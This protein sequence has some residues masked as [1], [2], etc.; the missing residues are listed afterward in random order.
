LQCWAKEEVQHGEALGRW[1]E[2]ADESFSLKQSFARFV[3]GYRPDVSVK[4]S[5]R[6]SLSGELIARCIVE[7]GTSSYYTTLAEAVEEPVL[8]TICLKI[9]ADELRHYKFFYD[10]LKTYLEKEKLNK[11]DRVK[12]GV[13]RM[14]E[15]E[16][17]ELAYA[18]YAANTA[19]DTIYNRA[20]YAAE[21]MQ[22]ALRYYKPHHVERMI[23]MLFKACGLRTNT[24]WQGFATKVA[25]WVRT[26][27]TER[28]L[29]QAA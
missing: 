17:D 3:A 7:T 14:F 9:A 8:K 22:R 25:W 28:T 20:H 29:K 5:I 1:A 21:Y 13:G 2:L 11:L 26:N 18:F 16:D 6:G 4:K 12:I 15:S 10:H 27:R 19:E 23:A 24:V